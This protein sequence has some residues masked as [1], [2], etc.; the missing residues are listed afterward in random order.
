MQ[1]SL[2]LATRNNA[3]MLRE[4][5]SALCL[6]NKPESWEIIIVDNGS[7]YKTW[8]VVTDFSDRLPVKYCFQP[9]PGK[10]VSLNLGLAEA[11]GGIILFTDDDVIPDRDWLVNHI[12]AM[13][14][15]PDINIVGGRIIVDQAIIPGWLAGSY[16]LRGI[17]VSE[18]DK[19]DAR[20][21]YEEGDY[22]FG[23]NMSVRRCRLDVRRTPWPEDIGPGTRIPVGDES[24]FCSSISAQSDTDRLYDPTCL[25]EH[26]P[27]IGKRFFIQSI[28]RCFLGGYTAAVLFPALSR[29]EDRPVSLVKYTGWRLLKLKSVQEFVCVGSRALGYGWGNLRRVLGTQPVSRKTQR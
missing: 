14:A 11:G 23:P 20:V 18:H 2:I 16:N 6:C 12:R 10:S 22:P 26:R 27:R 1:L 21:L 15:N 9:V 17:L 24:A 3:G 4:F 13:E 7:G 28:R 19:G 5:L 29:T 8:D 25:V